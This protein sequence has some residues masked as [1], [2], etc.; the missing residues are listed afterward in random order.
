MIVMRKRVEVFYSGR[1]QGVGFRWTT[2]EIAKGYEVAGHVRNLD[3]GRVELIAEG[4]EEEVEQFLQAI[5]HSQL[6]D[7]IRNAVVNRTATTQN[8]KGFVIA[9]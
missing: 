1:V 9:H 6:G 8:C 5:R 2:R 4:E 7:W 3:D